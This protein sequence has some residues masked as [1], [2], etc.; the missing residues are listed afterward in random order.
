MRE[1]ETFR[2]EL[3]QLRAAFP[4]KAIINRSELMDYL[5]KKRFWLDHHGFGSKEFTLVN[6][7]HKLSK[8]R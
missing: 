3:E 1:C 5:G 2:A 8:L 4:N 6:V 7:A